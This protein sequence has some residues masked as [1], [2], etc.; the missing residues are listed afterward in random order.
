MI[1]HVIVN[2]ASASGET[3]AVW[4][5]L[6]S[7]LRNQLGAFQVSFTEKPG[8]AVFIAAE[9]AAKG[10]EL[11]IACGGDGTVSEVAN[12]ILNS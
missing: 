1:P 8:D 11:I 7:E 4:P 3:A 5:R 2:P 10:A 12:G 6:A 9:A